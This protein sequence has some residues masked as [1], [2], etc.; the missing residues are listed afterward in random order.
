M[1]WL[2]FGI[3]IFLLLNIIFPSFFQRAPHYSLIAERLNL[4]YELKLYGVVI[5]DEDEEDYSSYTIYIG[6]YKAKVE[7]DGSFEI[8]FLSETK[9]DIAVVVLDDKDRICYCSKV[10][11][12]KEKKDLN[13]RLREGNDEVSRNHYFRGVYKELSGDS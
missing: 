6:G 1:S 7:K 2:L 3:T 4:P 8:L 12:E 9:E 11:F 5:S 13:I 10:S